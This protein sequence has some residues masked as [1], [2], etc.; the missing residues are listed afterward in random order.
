MKK[1]SAW[2]LILSLIVGGHLLAAR[3]DD[4]DIFGANV[5]PNVMLALTSSTK[6]NPPPDGTLIKSEPYLPST[7]Y[8]TPLTYTTL[9][10][11]KYVKS[12]PLCK[13]DPSPCYLFYKNTIA[14]VPDAD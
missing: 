9:K 2:F 3:A 4:S 6:M 5:K 13:P 7:T 1:A 11:Y 10:V 14:Q 8:S 12:T